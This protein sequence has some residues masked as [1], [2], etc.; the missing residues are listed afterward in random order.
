MNGLDV[1]EISQPVKSRFGYHIIEVEE[2]RQQ[3]VTNSSQRDKVRK[4]LFQRKLN[5]ELEA[6]QQQVRAEAYVDNRLDEQ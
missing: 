6:W 3:D 5:D 2:R 1:G 4:T